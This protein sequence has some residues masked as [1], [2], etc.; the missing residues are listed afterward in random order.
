MSLLTPKIFNG[1]L[2]SL[3]LLLPFLCTTS[4]AVGDITYE[5]IYSDTQSTPQEEPPQNSSNEYALLNLPPSSTS[6]Q[7]PVLPH[8]EPTLPPPVSPP[9][10]VQLPVQQL[11]PPSTPP[12]PSPPEHYEADWK[13]LDLRIAPPWYDDVKLGV[14]IHW[15]VYS[16]PSFGMS[17]L[18]VGYAEWFLEEYR[19]NMSYILCQFNQAILLL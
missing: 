16:V 8:P 19:G 12:P 18:D 17:H 11:P 7:P 15:G 13:S 3:V 10:V 5:T 14:F 9:S 4:G 1:F 6:G 2:F